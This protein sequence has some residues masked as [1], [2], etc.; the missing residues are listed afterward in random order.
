MGAYNFGAFDNDDASDWL[1]QLWESQGLSFLQRS[2]TLSFIDQIY[3]Q[4]PKGSIL[5]AASEV[6]AEGCG[7]G[8]SNLPR[9]ARN[10][11][12]RNAN[13]P[14]QQLQPSALRALKRVLGGRSEL[15]QLWRENNEL[16]IQWQQSV[17]G[18]KKRLSSVRS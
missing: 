10:W 12:A 9:Q 18:I 8:S 15:H 7:V 3:L 17:V 16:Y 4:A 13:A 6:I 14:Y 11:V 1:S 5:I 2:L